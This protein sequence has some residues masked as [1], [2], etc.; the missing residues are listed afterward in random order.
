MDLI[1][2]PHQIIIGSKAVSDDLVEYK[3]RKSGE[4]EFINL[5]KLGNFLEEMNV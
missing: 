5:D 4:T 1:G 2:L 3:N